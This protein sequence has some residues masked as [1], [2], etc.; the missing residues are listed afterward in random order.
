MVPRQRPLVELDRETA[1]RYSNYDTPF[2]ARNNST[3][4]R[5]HRVADGATQY[6]TLHPDGAW[7]ELARAEDL[8]TEGDLELV[9]TL[10]W[11]VK[12]S[13]LQLVDYGTFERAEAAG[14]PP[15][16]LI[17]DDYTRCQDEG[18]RLRDEGYQGVVAPSAA[19]PG[20]LNITL[21][22]RRVLSSWNAPAR[23]ASCIP[24]CIVARGCPSPGLAPRARYREQTHAGYA[25]F[26]ETLAERARLDAMGDRTNELEPLG[27]DEEQNEGDD[28]SF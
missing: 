8:R 7:A 10:I 17:D 11:A 24:A 16:A 5:W 19:L 28:A 27:T 1:F 2:W 12:I 9:R 26:Q 6:L 23:L 15:D 4:G 13:Q 20:V 25:E 14:L 21:F 3:D 18:R 22:G